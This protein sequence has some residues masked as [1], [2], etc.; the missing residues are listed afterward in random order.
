MT[1]LT[2][3]LV[4]TIF[5]CIGVGLLAFGL[6]MGIR[7]CRPDEPDNYQSKQ[8]RKNLFKVPR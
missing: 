1:A 2:A 7:L 6:V 5:T 8:V 3:D 4:L